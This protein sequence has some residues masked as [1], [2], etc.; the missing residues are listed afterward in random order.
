[1][2]HTKT[3]TFALN[4][5]NCGAPLPAA[6]GD[7]LAICLYC[8]TT[9]R[10][11]AGAP[12]APAT[13]P[14]AEATLSDEDMAEVRQHLIEARKDAALELYQEKTGADQA[15][16]RQ[17]MEGLSRELSLDI[18]RSQLLTPYGV[19]VVALSAVIVLAAVIAF[20]L[21]RL[22]FLWA[23]GLAM[24]GSWQL[25]YFML[26]IRTTLQ[27]RGARS[28]R[29]LTLKL[30]PI[31]VYKLGGK[32]IHTLKVLLEVQPDGEAPFQAEMRLPVRAE[33]MG[34]ARPG[35]ILRVKY[36]PGSPPRVVY[37]GR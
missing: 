32:D 25:Y 30:A 18:I 14:V 33:N 13:Q 16:A 7:A 17:A 26:S 1:M 36:L 20:V 3:A 12:G 19:L 24:F 4:C 37:V 5:P 9:S 34:S 28:A 27:F 10:L 15:D 11:Q 31:G 22:P 8:N 2:E 6:A 21:G 23:L 35:A 29:A